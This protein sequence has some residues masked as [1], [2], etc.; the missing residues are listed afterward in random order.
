M[1]SNKR[2][3]VRALRRSGQ[4][5][6]ALHSAALLLYSL[7]GQCQWSHRNEMG[8]SAGSC[9]AAVRIAG[10]PGSVAPMAQMHV[11]AHGAQMLCCT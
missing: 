5:D 9:C 10:L 8:H 2:R 7:M 3:A 11:D 6:L 4:L 1:R